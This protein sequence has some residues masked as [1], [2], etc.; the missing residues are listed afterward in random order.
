MIRRCQIRRDRPYAEICGNVIG[1]AMRPIDFLRFKLSCFG[2]TRF[3]PRSDRWTRITLFQDAPF[4]MELEGMP[5]DDW[6]LPQ[7]P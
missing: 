3:D 1:A 4:A 5:A 2:A 6:F 7:L